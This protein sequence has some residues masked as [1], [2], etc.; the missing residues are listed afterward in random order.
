[1]ILLRCTVG[2]NRADSPVV[3]SYRVLQ[4]RSGR[5]SEA[6][7]KALVA[8]ESEGL[9]HIGRTRKRNFLKNAKKGTSHFEGH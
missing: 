9:I 8:L 7:S 6:I 4:Q 5:S 2:W 1:M 3:L